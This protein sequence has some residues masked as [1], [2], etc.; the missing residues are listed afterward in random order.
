MPDYEQRT[1]SAAF[2]RVLG[3][4][5]DALAFEFAG[6]GWTF[7]AW[8]DASAKLF[9]GLA[10]LGG[11]VGVPIALQ[12]DNSAD[13]QL[14]WT[15][16]GLGG[17]IQV[18]VNTAHRGTFLSHVLNDSA[19]TI[20]IVE[21]NYIDR[22]ILVADEI[23]HLETLVVRGD[24]GVADALRERFRVV[25]LAEVAA[26]DP[27]TFGPNDPAGLMA[28]MYTS[29]TTGPSKGVEVT[30]VHAYTYSSREDSARA[31]APDD[32]MLVTLP[33][34]HLAGQWAGCY[35][36]LVHQCACYIEPGFSA[37][38]FWPTVR[39]HGITTTTLLGA[40][41][42][43]L[44]QQPRRS[45]DADNPLKFA[46]MSPL[47]TDVFGFA[48][49]FGIEISTAYGM[50]EIGAVM[51][52]TW[53]N[54]KPGEAGTVRP[55][56]E[57]RIVDMDGVDVPD[58]EVGELWARAADPRMTMRGYHGLPEKTA[59]TVVDGWVH[60]GDAFRR[61]EEGHYYFVDRM[62]DALRRRGENIS[63]FEVEKVINSHP[64]VLESAVVAAP[65]KLSEDEIK[66]V[67]IPRPDEAI[68]LVELTSFL[69]ERM[70]YFMVP[71]YVQLADSLPRTPTQKIQKH[72][73][74][75]AGISE[76]VWDREAVGIRVTREGVRRA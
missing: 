70:P 76:Q 72:L 60:T 69:A 15:A 50:S 46:G 66:A 19:A 40:M 47:A 74:R 62:K 51:N 37:S 11:R 33:M 12:L 8:Y 20:A 56:Y 44:Q 67:I 41:A 65:S 2:E 3:E 45:D 54:L 9:G 28:Y 4:R 58:G 13:M 1:L 18:P 39:R 49:R 36:A 30:H 10:Q 71:R 48:E 24:V 5:P 25:P 52:G 6:Q 34:F 42:E 17:A 55:G 35:S 73:L 57:L 27:Y 16:L 32:R 14:A 29:G 38:E 22:L 21:D 75:D 31:L 64:Q 53:D 23:E 61:D 7:Q 63:S 68:D 59:E 43:I 26:A